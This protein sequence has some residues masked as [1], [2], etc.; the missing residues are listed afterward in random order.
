MTSDGLAPA[1]GLRSSLAGHGNAESA[2]LLPKA[3]T[4]GAG[5]QADTLATSEVGTIDTLR[6]GV[7]ERLLTLD[8]TEEELTGR[9]ELAPPHRPP[10]PGR[11]YAR[12][13]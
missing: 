13:R 1:A 5:H 7:R 10:V 4:K 11:G 6:P 3:F 9:A 2:L 8:V 12:R